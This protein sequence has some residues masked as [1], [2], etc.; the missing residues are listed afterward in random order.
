M[1]R[2]TPMGAEVTVIDGSG[3]DNEDE[4]DEDDDYALKYGCQSV[5]LKRIKDWF[6]SV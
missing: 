5:I 3:E 2:H 4:D 1:Y 6:Y